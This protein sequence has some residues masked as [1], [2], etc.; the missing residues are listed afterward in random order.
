MVEIADVAQIYSAAKNPAVLEGRKTE[1]QVLAEFLETFEMHHNLINNDT[2]NNEVTLEEFLEYY[3]NVSASIDDDSYFEVMMDGSW[4]LSG[5]ANPYA[6]VD[7]GWFEQVRPGTATSSVYQYKNVDP[8]ATNNIRVD[9]TMRTGLESHDN[10]WSTT[11]TYY[12]EQSPRKSMSNPKHLQPQRTHQQITGS[13]SNL[14]DTNRKQQLIH[15]DFIRSNLKPL[16]Q[17]LPPSAPKL[18]SNLAILRSQIK[19]CLFDSGIQGALNLLKE[20]KI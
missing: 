2:P 20:F 4:N 6:R 15:D 12:G 19:T 5:H 16:P 17:E 18:D 9:A 8:Y 7:K 3:N 10:P 14:I 11:E 1:D 13:Q